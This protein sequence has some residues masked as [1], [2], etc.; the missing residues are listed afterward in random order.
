M[1]TSIQAAFK[2]SV[3]ISKKIHHVSI[4][5]YPPINALRER[6]AVYCEIIRIYIA[7]QH[8]TFCVLNRVTTVL[9]K[10]CVDINLTVLGVCG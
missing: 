2:N 9:R 6:N 1:L 4:K 3:L 10:A 7:R 5:K 8:Q